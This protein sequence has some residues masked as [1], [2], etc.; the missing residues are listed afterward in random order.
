MKFEELKVG[1][2]AQLGKTITEADI[3]MF[4][5]VSLDCNPLHLNEEIAKTSVFGKR[6]AHGMLGASLISAVL[7]T[8]LPGEGTIYLGQDL[9][10][11]A[12]V[13]IGDTITAEVEIEE[14]IPE[15]NRVIL[16]TICFNQK[17]QEVISGR[18]F[19]MKK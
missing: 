12:P 5:A 1:M 4:A 9:K 2:K 11:I 3:L 14:I 7:G 8:Q 6:I 18:A 15:K 16:K 19:V 13:F 17:Q 10:F